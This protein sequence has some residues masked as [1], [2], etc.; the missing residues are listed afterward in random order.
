MHNLLTN[1]LD[2]VV[3]GG[4]AR[5]EI[6]IGAVRAG[7]DVLLTVEDSGQGVSS[8]ITAQLF[9]PFRDH[10]GGW[11]GARSCNQPFTAAQ[12]GW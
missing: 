11:H 5:R 1:A 10:E 4:G 6:H 2:A 12:P 7:S 8:E 3:A 9:N